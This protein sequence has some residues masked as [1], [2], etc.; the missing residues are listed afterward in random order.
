MKQ[1]Q[2]SP[3]CSRTVSNPFAYRSLKQ[4]NSEEEDCCLPPLQQY[5]NEDDSLTH[6]T[7]YSYLSA[8]TIVKILTF[9]LLGFAGGLLYHHTTLSQ[10]QQISSPFSRS[11][12]SSHSAQQHEQMLAANDHIVHKLA[13]ENQQHEAELAKLREQLE[14]KQHELDA[15]PKLVI[16]RHGSGLRRTVAIGEDMIAMAERAD[17]HEQSDKHA[18][19]WTPEVHDARLEAAQREAEALLRGRAAARDEQ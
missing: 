7:H 6:D 3:S 14:S 17:A 13:T 15:Q 8:P 1:Q 2:P 5:F 16:T 11:N 12:F 4:K 10:S 9:V 18:L 19:L